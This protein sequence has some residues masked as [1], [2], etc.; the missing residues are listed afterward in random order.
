MSVYAAI[1]DGAA[2]DGRNILII[3]TGK[4]S[5]A[6]FLEAVVRTESGAI[7]FDPD[8]VQTVT[9]PTLIHGGIWPHEEGTGNEL[10]DDL[11]V[12]NNPV[13]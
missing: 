8:V 2:I 13:G 10:P 3:P 6:V 5:P 11:I 12:H 9:P 7:P 4:R 1:A